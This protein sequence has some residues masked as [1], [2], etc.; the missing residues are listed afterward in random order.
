MKIAYWDSGLRW[1][2][3]NLRWGNPAYLLEP[4]DPGYVPP[5][6][7]PTPT[8]KTKRMRRT[9]Y[10][11]LRQADQVI[12]LTNFCNKIAGYAAVLGLTPA[13]VSAVQAEC[14]WLSYV[15][16]TWLPA[17][18]TWNMACTDA[19]TEAQ[20]GPGLAA[21][22]LPVFTAPALPT[23][24]VPVPPGALTRV[25]ALIQTMKD[26]GKVTEAIGTDLG[27]L[28][29][30]VNLPDLATLQPLIKVRALTTGVEIDWGWAGHSDVLDALLIQ[31]DRGDGQGWRL[32]VHDT[33]PR[34]Q[35]TT[36][37]PPAL[38]RWQYRA[39]YIKDDAQVG[40]WSATVNVTVGG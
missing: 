2:D 38:T 15:L 29:A 7:L 31:V 18:R 39:V 11:P 5:P 34:Y 16:Q 4:G 9:N 3:P 24:V 37:L 13:Q 28:G 10:Y 22:I 27:I 30:P 12:W 20:T 14:S 6:D 19:V 33:T 26:S 35:D 25:F 1:D 36:P 32:L 21:Q 8:K 17:V 40:Q 23:D